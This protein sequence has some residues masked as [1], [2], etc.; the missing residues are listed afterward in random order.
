MR[1]LL[2]S[3]R[4]LNCVQ[5]HR[6]TSD[7][8]LRPWSGTARDSM[9]CCCRRV[10]LEREGVSAIHEADFMFL[11]TFNPAEGEPSALLRDRIALI[12]NAN[13][14]SSADETVE[15]IARTFRFDNDPSTFPE[16]YAF[17]TAEI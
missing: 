2:R 9:P 8:P 11:G 16:E 4:G 14:E 15:M 1:H 5:H 10:R 7:S 13:A 3:T 17:E 12:V 6:A